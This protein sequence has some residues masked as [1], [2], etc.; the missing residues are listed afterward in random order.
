[1]KKVRR[2]WI[3]QVDLERMRW[4]R[5]LMRT[6]SPDAAYAALVPLEGRLAGDSEYGYP[7]ASPLRIPVISMLPNVR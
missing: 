1:M 3:Q 4:A 5:A 6:K 2:S 7:L